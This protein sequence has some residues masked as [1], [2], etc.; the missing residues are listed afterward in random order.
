[1]SL[2]VPLREVTGSAA[3]AP[4]SPGAALRRSGCEVVAGSTRLDSVFLELGFLLEHPA[5]GI[6]VHQRQEA[7]HRQVSHPD[8]RALDHPRSPRALC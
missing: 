8:G 6:L 3:A 2:A 1:M 5:A 7:R 4:D